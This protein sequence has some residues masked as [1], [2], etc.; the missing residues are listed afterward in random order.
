MHR[1]ATAKG[2]MSSS[3]LGPAISN[4][5]IPLKAMFE[6]RLP[7]TFLPPLTKRKMPCYTG[8]STF[9]HEMEKTPPPVRTILE[10]PKEKSLRN[11]KKKEEKKEEILQK[12]ISLWKPPSGE[13]DAYKTLFV[14]RLSYE[15]TENQLRREMEQYGKIVKV[16]LVL[17][18][19]N[20]KPRGYAFVEFEK[21]EDM[22][23]AFRKADGKK[24]EGRRIVVDVERG[25]T[26]QDWK[27]RRL[28][29]GIGE[30]RKGGDDVNIKYSGR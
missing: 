29:G 19:E 21:E 2:Q 6:P 8:L 13:G 3:G 15:I 5:P 17:N 20:E 9:V 25:R 27:P 28:G 18:N 14:G 16:Q 12:S 30:T 23:V 1:K 26:V 22:K 10:T 4:L 24:M 11:L 7:L